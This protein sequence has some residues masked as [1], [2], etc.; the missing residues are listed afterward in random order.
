M[1]K[2]KICNIGSG[3][4]ALVTAHFLSK[5]DINIDLVSSDFRFIPNSE[6][7]I[8]LS[9]TNLISLKDSGF[10]KNKT[11]KIWPVSKMDLYEGSNDLSIKKIFSFDKR[12]KHILY[13]TKY[14]DLIRQAK[15][16]VKLKNNIKFIEKLKKM[17]FII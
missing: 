7:S 4:T 17:N 10:F 5:H 16:L 15:K 12:N 2:Q 8:A 14:N 3:L 9:N 13:M 1:K 6:R 11:K